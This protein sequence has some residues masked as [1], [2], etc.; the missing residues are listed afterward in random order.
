[1]ST[2]CRLTYRV[3]EIYNNYSGIRRKV[4]GKIRVNVMNHVNHL[5]S[6][7]RKNLT[8]HSDISFQIS[9]LGL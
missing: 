8:N 1:M 2:I 5:M 9:G 7:S 4:N 6:T 3:P